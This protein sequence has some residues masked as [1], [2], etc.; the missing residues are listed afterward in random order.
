MS[1][2]SR[3]AA[4]GQPPQSRGS[5]GARNSVPRA[6]RVATGVLNDIA[7]GDCVVILAETAE[8]V[9]LG[10]TLSRSRE[11]RGL[12]HGVRRL[13]REHGWGEAA[14]RSLDA[15]S[16]RTPGARCHSGRAA[17]NWSP[18]AR[19]ERQTAYRP[20]PQCACRHLKTRYRRSM[21][22]STHG[23]DGDPPH[24]IAVLW[25]EILVSCLNP[26]ELRASGEK[27]RR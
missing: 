20:T 1:A 8:R 22:V 2:A 13:A 14:G 4:R 9:H 21:S 24:T 18:S 11:G 12:A 16:T 15:A 25:F 5:L 3:G 7:S 26:N 6:P 23:L 19:Q 10:F 27:A 17:L